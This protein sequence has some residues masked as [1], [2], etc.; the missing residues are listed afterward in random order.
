MMI[1]IGLAVRQHICPTFYSLFLKM[2]FHG[3]P[4]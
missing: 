1:E 2:D 3:F 4:S